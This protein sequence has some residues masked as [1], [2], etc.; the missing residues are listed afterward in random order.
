MKAIVS[1]LSVSLLPA[2]LTALGCSAAESEGEARNDGTGIERS[3]LSSETMRILEALQAGSDGEPGFL[4]QPVGGPIQEA[5]NETLVYDPASAIKIVVGIGLLQA[6]DGESGFDL[7]TT[8]PHFTDTEG[9]CPT[10]SGPTQTLTLE[11][12]LRLML[13]ISDNAATRTLIDFLGGFDAINATAQSIGMTSTTMLGYPGCL[14]NE[15]KLVD[16][17]LLYEGIADGS[18]ISPESRAALFAN[19]PANASDFSGT[20]FRA[21]AIVDSEAPAAGVTSAEADLFKNEL[22]LHYKAGNGTVCT[23]ETSCLTVFAISGLAEIPTCNG[24]E[25]GH[26]QYDWGLFIKDGT[27]QGAVA[28]TFFANQAEPLRVPIRDALDGWST[29]ADGMTGG[30]G[31][32]CSNN[33]DCDSFICA[34]GT[35]QPASCAPTCNQGAPCG[36]DQDCGSGVCGP[37][38]TC[39][40]PACAPDCATGEVCGNNGDCDSF[41]CTNN[42]CT[43]SSCAPTCGTGAP[44]GSDADCGSDVC[45]GGLCA[46]PACSPSCG[47]GSA[48][49]TNGDCASF[50]CTNN[51]CSAPF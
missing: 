50:V 47:A 23:S 46:P 31:A 32:P 51:T 18:L 36:S 13:E 12:L 44:C 2:V 19:M 5:F 41:V 8:I 49:G 30:T 6:I 1:K 48:C 7:D 25:L 39:A 24:E 35:C 10:G 3:A 38:G 9:S 33:G 20:L 40:A 29:C 15:T 27:D 17:A 4:V 11:E 16:M 45:T 14:A 28:N 43:P 42:L 21:R 26:A 37:G 22:E 34:G